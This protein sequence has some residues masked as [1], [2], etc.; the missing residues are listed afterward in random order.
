MLDTNVVRVSVVTDDF[1][2]RIKTIKTKPTIAQATAY[3][4]EIFAATKIPEMTPRDT[5]CL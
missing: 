3:K 4:E 2:F 1:G 5:A